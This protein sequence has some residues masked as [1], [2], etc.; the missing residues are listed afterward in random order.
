MKEISELKRQGL[1]ITQIS[2]L[3]GCDPKTI[4]KYLD[5]PTTPRYGPRQPRP[6]LLD[7]FKAYLHER[8][9][10]G[11]WNAVVLL[12]ELQERG[13]SG[14]YTILRT[15]LQPL[16]REAHTVAVRRFETPPGQ[17]AQVDW[18]DL[19]ELTDAEGTYHKLNGF[20]MTLGYSRTMFFDIAPDQKLPSFLRMHEAAFE[21][22]GGVPHEILYDNTKTVVL[23]TLTQGVDSRGEVRLHPTFADFARY[24]GFTP[25]LCRPYRPQTKGKGEN[26]I[27]Y[28]RKNFVCGRD[29]EGFADL[30]HQARRWTAEVAN[31]RVHGSTYRVVAE[32][33]QQEQ[34]ALQPLAKR[35]AYPLV[36]ECVRRVSRDAFVCWQSNRY[37]VPWQHAG[38]EVLVRE[39]GAVVEILRE[40]TQVA[41]HALCR[42]RHQTLLIPAHHVGIPTVGTRPGKARLSLKA[43]APEVE[44]RSLAVYEALLEEE[45]AA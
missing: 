29:A 32:A 17:Q 11:V 27:G 25:R 1:S 30:R 26:G 21:Y 37:S 15:Y 41:V 19:G 43:A 10:A 22:L 44:V 45:E 13:Y 2:A 3:T 24:W 35:R 28:V 18:G 34:P 38:Q 31:V 42:E 40:Q 39:V 5:N 36:V 6:S 12:R 20:V 4:R 9:A 14:G 33:W 7:P 23:K 8:L 16:R